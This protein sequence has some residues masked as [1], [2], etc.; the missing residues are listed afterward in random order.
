[1]VPA[2]PALA[3]GPSPLPPADSAAV[4]PTFVGR[5]SVAGNAFADSSR[6]LRTFELTT[7]TRYS[8]EAVRRGI[9]KLF[10]LGMEPEELIRQ[11]R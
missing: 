4:A 1:M 6:I 11:S 3:Q 2:P 9:R 10:A 5:V 8:E 7:G